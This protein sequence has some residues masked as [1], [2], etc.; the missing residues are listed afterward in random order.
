VTSPHSGD[1]LH[2]LPFSGCRPGWTIKPPTSP[3][4][5]V[6]NICEPHQCPCGASVDAKGLHGLSCKGGTGRSARYHAFN[7]LLWRALSKADIPAVKEPSGLFRTDGKRPGGV[8]QLPWRTGKCVTWD[9]TVFDTLASSYILATSQA[10]GAAAETA[11]NRKTSKCYTQPVLLVCA[12]RSR[13]H[14][15]DQRGRDDFLGDLGRRITKHTDDH[16]E[17]AFLFLFLFGE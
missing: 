4:A 15:S 12:G 14:V 1:W 17:S 10:P 3:W 5:S 16:R 13:D 2:A 6:A 11:A 8:T 7:D 9:V